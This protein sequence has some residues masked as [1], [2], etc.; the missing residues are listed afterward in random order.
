MDLYNKR[1]L[2]N[3]SVDIDNQQALGRFLDTGLIIHSISK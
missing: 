3:V 1:Y 2:D